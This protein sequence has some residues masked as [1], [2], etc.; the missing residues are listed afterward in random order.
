MLALLALTVA[1]ASPQLAAP[2]ATVVLAEVD[3]PT[4]TPLTL[5]WRDAGDAEL[6]A[7]VWSLPV[8]VQSP[9]PT[10]V[11]FTLEGEREAVYRL[12]TALRRLD[13]PGDLAAFPTPSPAVTA[14]Q[15]STL[16]GGTVLADAATD[17]VVMIGNPVQF[18][19]VRRLLTHEPLVQPSDEHV[20][21]FHVEH[22]R[23]GTLNAVADAA[24]YRGG[25]DVSITRDDST[26]AL[27]LLG[28][29][30]DVAALMA[31]LGRADSKLDRP[32]RQRG[33]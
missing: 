25:M 8:A 17:Y 19:A 20:D 24:I 4:S 21:V 30:D 13:A 5:A 16:F 14:A 10:A 28:P 32:E 3:A 6:L 9:R 7:E 18:D 22:T 31:L 33:R 12:S 11:E 26:N 15:L 29:A 1:S 23:V 27:V 2:A